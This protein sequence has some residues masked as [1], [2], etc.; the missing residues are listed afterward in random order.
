MK[1]HTTAIAIAAALALTSGPAEAKPGK[2][3][4]NSGGPPGQSGK[5]KPGKAPKK[6]DIPGPPNV[7]GNGKVKKN[8]IPSIDPKKAEKDWR[9]AVKKFEDKDRDA[10]LGY[11]SKHKGHPHGLPP[12]LAKKVASG[13]PLPPGWQKKLSPGWVITDDWWPSLTPLPYSDFAGLNAAPDT[14]LYWYGDRVVRVYEPR[15]E[16]LD[17]IV[18]PTIQLP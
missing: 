11:F 6:K 15:R 12:G 16:I 3:K 10:V 8:D 17:V 14:G 7:K 2:G 9:K 4:G 18:V 1:F 5:A 13:K